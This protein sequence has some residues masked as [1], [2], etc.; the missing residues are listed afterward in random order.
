M[1]HP[2]LLRFNG[3]VN[4]NISTRCKEK[5][6]NILRSGNNLRLKS[7]QQKESSYCNSWLRPFHSGRQRSSKRKRAVATGWPA[8]N[9]Y[10][11]HL[12]KVKR[13][14]NKG[15]THSLNYLLLLGN[16]DMESHRL[17]LKR[18]IL[19]YTG[20]YFYALNKISSTNSDQTFISCNYDEGLQMN[21][22][23]II[24]SKHVLTILR[25]ST[26]G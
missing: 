4:C 18:N 14:Q 25:A 5:H 10:V 11:K 7:F 23:N 22:T 8:A 6:K 20:F 16:L 3:H 2:P 13:P 1:F 9:N 17:K 19:I 26:I 12:H 21:E 24:S 15:S